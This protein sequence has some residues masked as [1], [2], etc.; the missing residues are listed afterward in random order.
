MSKK[1][2]SIEGISLSYEVADAITLATLKESK[3]LIKNF[4]KKHVKKGEYMH[5]EDYT[6]NQAYLHAI[7]T[8]IKYYGHAR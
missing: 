1:A 2:D 3:K 6:N 7:D 8:L 4:L 5:E